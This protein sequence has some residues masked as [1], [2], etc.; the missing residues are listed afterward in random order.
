MICLKKRRKNHVPIFS[1][2]LIQANYSQ[3]NFCLLGG[4]I[5]IPWH[6]LSMLQ[7]TSTLFG[8]AMHVAESCCINE[9]HFVRCRGQHYI[10]CSLCLNA[11]YQPQT[12]TVRWSLRS[13]PPTCSQYISAHEMLLNWNLS[14]IPE[15]ESAKKKIVGYSISKKKF[16][17]SFPATN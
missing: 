15:I 10:H 12:L 17:R 13:L 14:S 7:N 9:L 1:M 11:V 3:W 6:R 16:D 4:L 2:H 8:F 5:S